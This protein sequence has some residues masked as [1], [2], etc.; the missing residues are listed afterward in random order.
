MCDVLGW[1]W[2]RVWWC[3]WWWQQQQRR[4]SSSPSPPLPLAV[5]V[6]SSS[7]S[8]SAPAGGWRWRR[9]WRRRRR[10]WWW[11]RCGGEGI[12]DLCHSPP[13]HRLPGRTPRETSLTVCHQRPAHPAGDQDARGQVGKAFQSSACNKASLASWRA[14]AKRASAL[15][16][17]QTMASS[18]GTLQGFCQWYMS[19]SFNA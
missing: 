8:S 2:W 15:P 16:L 9:S 18:G 17:P 5:V 1:W 4:R 10:W 7:S 14:S 13:V 6:T 3:W 19:A 12:G 11:G